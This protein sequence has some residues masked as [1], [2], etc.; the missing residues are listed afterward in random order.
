MGRWLELDY[1]KVTETEGD[2]YSN[3]EIIPQVM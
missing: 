2:E 3:G 1:R